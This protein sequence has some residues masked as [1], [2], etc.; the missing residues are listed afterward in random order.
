MLGTTWSANH[1]EGTRSNVKVGTGITFLWARD[2]LQGL[3]G[4]DLTRGCLEEVLESHSDL[5]ISSLHGTAQHSTALHN[6]I[7]LYTL[8]STVNIPQLSVSVF[9]NLCTSD[10]FLQFGI[11]LYMC[12]D[13]VI[14]PETSTSRLFLKLLHLPAAWEC[15]GTIFTHG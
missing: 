7:Y 15:S 12:L 8:H 3:T 4:L 10:R 14:L 5:E 2:Y 9:M 11:G 1:V 13:Y 6:R